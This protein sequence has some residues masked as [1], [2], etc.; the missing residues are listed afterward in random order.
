MASYSC[1]EG[2]IIVPNAVGKILWKLSRD[3]DF[4]NKMYFV[5]KVSCNFTPIKL[6]L[7]RGSTYTATLGAFRKT[8]QRRLIP[9]FY[10]LVVCRVTPNEILHTR[11]LKFVIYNSF[12]PN[13]TKRT[14]HLQVN[15]LTLIH[16]AELS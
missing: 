1:S 2:S 12:R 15:S 8:R 9:T 13:W 16:G 4:H 10:V 14:K 3:L 11:N 5:V 6:M 7:K